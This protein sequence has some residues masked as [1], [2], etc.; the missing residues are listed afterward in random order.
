MARLAAYRWKQS[1]RSFDLFR[2]T[3]PRLYFGREDLPSAYLNTSYLHLETSIHSLANYFITYD[4][5]RAPSSDRPGEGLGLKTLSITGKSASP[6]IFRFHRSC[7]SRRRIQSV[8]AGRRTMG[9]GKRLRALRS[10]IVAGTICCHGNMRAEAHY[11][12]GSIQA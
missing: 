11:A 2:T 4:L 3:A 1:M 5:W 12:V 6:T 9:S 10:L 8:A 7:T